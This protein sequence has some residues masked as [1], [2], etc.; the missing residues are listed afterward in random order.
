MRGYGRQRREKRRRHNVNE[1]DRLSNLPDCILLHILSFMNV[2][3]AVQTSMLSK[4]WKNLWKHLQTLIV[5][6]SPGFSTF[7][8]FSR[9]V[10]RL[11][12]LRDGLVALHDL[13]FELNLPI[14]PYL[15]ERI[16]KYAVSH[17]VQQLGLT[18][19][20]DTGNFPSCIFSSQTL[21]SLKLNV[22]SADHFFKMLFPKSLN[23]P[24]LTTLHLEHF[25]FCANGNDRC[26]K[27]FSSLNKLNSLNIV[28]CSLRDAEVLCISST[29]LCNLTVHNRSRNFLYS[30]EL[31][32]PN[33]CTFA[34][35]GVPFQ[36]LSGSRNISSLEQVNID[37]QILSNE[38]A[39]IDLGTCLNYPTSTPFILLSWLEELANIK[40]LTISTST[41]Q[42]LSL[43]PHLLELKYPILGSLK[44]LKVIHKPLSHG[45]IKILIQAKLQKETTKS[46]KAIAAKLRRAMKKEMFSS[47]PDGTMDFLLQNSPSAKVDI[48]SCSTQVDTL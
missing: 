44:S 24:A 43:I 29:T 8:Q 5:H 14:Q 25:A 30:I 31:S 26:A 18:V 16:A 10:S 7:P 34:F 12:T 42:V 4:K 3:Y 11:L 20:C 33:L 38:E 15:L 32:S 23:L 27:P 6:Y 9:F 28:S 17:N 47:I 48:I 19:M 13:D 21:T 37:A 36:L 1:N 35:T 22:Q 39:K 45:F 40:S 41:L 2:K 46:G